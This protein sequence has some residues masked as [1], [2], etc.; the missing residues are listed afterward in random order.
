MIRVMR[1][2][3]TEAVVICLAKCLSQK[4][5]IL[6]SQMNIRIQAKDSDDAS[7]NDSLRRKKERHPQL[8]QDIM[9]MMCILMK[10]CQTIRMMMDIMDTVD[11]MNMVNVI[12]VIIIMTEDMKEKPPQ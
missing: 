7:E 6:S 11:I 1:D 10:R 12:E 5:R 3:I 8:R 9:M 2:D 4:V